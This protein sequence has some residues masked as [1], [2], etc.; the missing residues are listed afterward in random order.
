MSECIATSMC[1][2][3]QLTNRT[4]EK[5]K[6]EYP[7]S[8]NYNL[9]RSMPIIQQALNF[10]TITDAMF[11]NILKLSGLGNRRVQEIAAPRRSL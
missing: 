1:H 11:A 3:I 4:S 10:Q 5:I 8:P 2:A 9:R 6:V 7:C